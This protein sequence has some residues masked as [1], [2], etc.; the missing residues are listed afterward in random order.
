[1]KRYVFIAVLFILALWST[2]GFAEIGESI[3]M[4]G[5][6]AVGV[7]TGFLKLVGGT[8][9]LVGEVLLLPFQIF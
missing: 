1:M 8:L 9:R 2:A 4:I 5:E 6:G 7:P 3:G